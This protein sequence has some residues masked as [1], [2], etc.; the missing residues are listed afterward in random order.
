MSSYRTRGKSAL[1]IV[2]NKE[3]N[4]NMIEKYVFE[5]SEAQTDDNEQELEKIY[6]QNI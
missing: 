4:I 1:N 6:I 2:L 3:T 5:T